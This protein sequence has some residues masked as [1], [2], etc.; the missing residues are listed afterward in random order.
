MAVDKQPYSYMVLFMDKIQE[1]NKCSYLGK[2]FQ[3][4]V[5]MQWVGLGWQVDFSTFAFF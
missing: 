3:A 2:C 5:G 4:E 1:I